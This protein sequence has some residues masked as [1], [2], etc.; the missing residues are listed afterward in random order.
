M[1]P[2]D[3]PAELDVAP[4]WELKPAWHL[5]FFSSFFSWSCQQLVVYFLSFPI[6]CF[7]EMV[8]FHNLWKLL[9]CLNCYRLQATTLRKSHLGLPENVWF[10]PIDG[11]FQ[12]NWW[13]MVINQWRKSGCSVVSGIRQL[14]QHFSPHFPH[15][16]PTSCGIHRI[17]S[18]LSNLRSCA[19]RT[20]DPTLAVKQSKSGNWMELIQCQPRILLN[21][22]LLIRG[23][24]LQ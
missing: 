13:S 6:F 23:V 2:E 20:G 15:I 18:A 17:A 7:L 16:F 10:T 3:E 9:N 19:A 21:H 12:E 4:G 1:L 14:P 11:N 22:G 8:Y 24:L 5:H